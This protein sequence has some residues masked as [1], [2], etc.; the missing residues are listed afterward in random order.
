MR[1]LGPA[2]AEVL[3]ESAERGGVALMEKEEP[4]AG[5]DL[6]DDAVEKGQP[7]RA[8]RWLASELG[9]RRPHQVVHPHVQRHED[10]LLALEM[11]VEGGL[12]HPQ[13]LGDL[14]KRGRVVALLHEE[15]EGDVENP[16]AGPSGRRT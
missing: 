3:V 5:G 13:A 8:A 11:V 12:G 1:H 6:I 14:A 9:G 15:L 16:F 4:A 7:R 10:V 2:M